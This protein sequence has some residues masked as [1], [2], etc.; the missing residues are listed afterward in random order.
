[1]CPL[2]LQLLVLLP[3]GKASRCVDDC[4]TQSSSSFV[5]ERGPSDLYMANHEE[6]EHKPDL[7]V[8]VPHLIGSSLARES[9]RQREKIASRLGRLWT[10]PETELHPTKAVENDHAPLEIQPLTQP[11]DERKMERSPL[12]EEAKKFW[13]RFMFRK[14]PASQGV[15]LPIKSHEVHW[16]TCR[17]VPFNQTIA[18]KDC[19]KAV[20]PNNLCFGKCGSIH[21]PGAE[22]HP[23]NF[24]SHCSPT[25][26]TTVHLR[27]NCTSPA[28][29]VKMLIQ[30]AEC[31]CMAKREHGEGHVLPA[32]AQ[33]SFIP[34][35]SASKAIP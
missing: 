28:P 25:K 5:L 24:C 11:A 32:A 17:T 26:F 6:A 35:L 9:Q 2:I 1:M 15:I 19:E 34:G 16:E 23:Y 20:V 31:Q 33:D 21:F 14:G 27:L 13:H 10:K 4:P 7:F 12:Q 29:V 22:T 30:V 3:L 18:H 8:A